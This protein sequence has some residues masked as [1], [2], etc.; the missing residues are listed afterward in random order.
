MIFSLLITPHSLKEIRY[1]II[2]IRSSGV[3]LSLLKEKKF[4]SPTSNF[5]IFLE[6]KKN[7]EIFGL[8]IHDQSNPDTPQTYIAE[9]GRF[10]NINDIEFLRLFNGTIQIYNNTENRLS[11]VA[12]NTYD[13]NLLPYGKK[14]S[15]YIYPD[16]LSTSEIINNLRMKMQREYNTNEK[17]QFANLHSRIIN[18]FYIFFYSLLPLLMIRFSARPD[19]SWTY[20][21]IA[22]S[23]IAFTVQILQITLSN[24]LIENNYIVYFNYIFPLS[25][26]ICVIICL[27]QET[28][29]LFKKRN[30]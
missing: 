12:F 3:H 10:I 30:A 25:L 17:E 11:E 18:P 20:P 23:I 13:L 5:T 2:D 14:E 6:E 29:Y 22:V 21:I 28:L 24:L 15:T 4:I 16:E 27:N 8:L 7:D 1:K 26:I 9:K 19:D